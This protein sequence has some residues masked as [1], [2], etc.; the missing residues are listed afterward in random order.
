MCMSDGL[1]VERGQQHNLLQHSSVPAHRGAALR[2]LQDIVRL[3]RLHT[4]H[5][6]S[7]G[8]EESTHRGL[9]SEI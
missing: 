2:H 7:E 1:Q 5:P 8:L 4:L 6:T 9:R 3:A